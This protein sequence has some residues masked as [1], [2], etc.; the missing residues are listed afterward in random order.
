V[1][2]VEIREQLPEFA[3][4][5]LPEPERVVV[6]RH[7]QWCAGCRKEATELGS[8][9]VTFAYA[10]E[11]APVPRGLGDRIVARIRQ[12]AGAPGTSRRTRASAAL[13]IAA[14]ITVAA[15]GWGSAMAGRA[16][17]FAD[18]AAAAEARRERALATFGRVVRQLVP[19]SQLPV[20]ETHMGQL[21]PTAGRLGGGAVLQLVSPRTL[22][23]TIVMVNGLERDPAQMPYRVTL[24][25]AAGETLPVGRITE[26]DSTGGADVVRQFE[27]QDLT[28]YTAVLV[29]NASGDV[30]LSGT[31]DQSAGA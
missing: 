5:V 11:P 1:S 6:E 16:D 17:R 13:A 30:V 7:L 29:T 21:V 31:V 14:M 27:N 25:N 9:V 23:F 8:A 2:C 20:N 4:G 3:V 12:A 18:Q 28:G 22:D 15:L 10:L 19:I 26:L 24:Q